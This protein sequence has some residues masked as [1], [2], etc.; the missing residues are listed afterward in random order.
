MTEI[1]SKLAAIV[2]NKNLIT[3][4]SD[5]APYLDEPRKKFHGKAAAIV[6]PQT[7][8][9]VS[10]VLYLANETDTKIVPQGGNTGLV[11]GQVPDASGEQIVLSLKRLNKT[12]SVDPEQNSMVLDAGVT[13]QQ[14]QDIAAQSNRLFPLS[15]ASQG[16]C[17]IGGNLASNAGGL[18]VVAYGNARELC[19][20]LEVVMADGRIWDGLNTLRK[21]NTGYDLKNL[22]IGSEGTLGVITAAALKLFPKQ[23]SKATAFIAISEPKHALS[24]LNL[25]QQQSGNR[26]TT[27]ELMPRIGVEMTV[28]HKQTRDPFARPYPWYVLLEFSS[29]Q[30]GNGV[31]EAMIQTLEKAIENEIA[32]DAVIAQSGQQAADLWAIRELIP[33]TQREEGG[34]IKH[35]ISVPLSSMPAFLRE[36]EKAVLALMP[37]ARPV[38]FGHVGDGNIHFNITQ[39]KGADTKE[40][41]ARWD[42]V[43]AVVHKIAHDMGGSISAEHGIGQLKAALLPSVKSPLELEMMRNMKTMFDPKNTLNPGKILR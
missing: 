41:L 38:P 7:T 22:F 12:R 23:N 42:E 10:R 6:L 37:N 3:D 40:F 11:G 21:N 13:L 8:E 14:A 9:Q 5:Q 30:F 24:L 19:L 31:E 15:L 43:N 4:A 25:A 34:S 17:T 20:G 35:D 36:A 33:E 1:L 28:T 2:G 32:L 29:P 18:N 27:I 39:P 16:T 26:V